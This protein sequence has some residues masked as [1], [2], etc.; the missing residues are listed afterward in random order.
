VWAVR[1][2]A[3]RPGDL[4]T[5][6]RQLVAQQQDLHRLPVVRS[7]TQNEQLDEPPEHPV[8]GGVRQRH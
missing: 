6:H 4:P 1:K 5:K 2:R 8:N 3:T 7:T